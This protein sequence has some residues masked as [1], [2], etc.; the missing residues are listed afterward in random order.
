[1]LFKYIDLTGKVIAF[2]KFLDLSIY[3]NQNLYKCLWI[4]NTIS[5]CIFDSTLM[6]KVEFLKRTFRDC[7]F[8][9]LH[10]IKGGFNESLFDSCSFLNVKFD[11]SDL[12]DVRFKNCVFEQVDLNGLFL[13]EHKITLLFSKQ[14]TITSIATG[15]NR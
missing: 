9:N 1:M 12:S 11:T 14:G 10:F 2:S 15:N 7:T 8:L 3:S 13:N 5:N 6:K 4:E